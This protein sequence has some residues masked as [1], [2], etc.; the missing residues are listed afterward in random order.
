MVNN[1]IQVYSNNEFHSRTATDEILCNYCK[2]KVYSQGYTD[3][4]KNLVDEYLKIL[5]EQDPPF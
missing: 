1:I 4:W 3:G 5:E 2:R